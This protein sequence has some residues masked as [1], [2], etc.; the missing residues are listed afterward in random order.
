MCCD[1]HPFGGESGASSDL[2]G[3]SVDFDVDQTH[4]A[5]TL[6]SDALVV[7]KRWYI[8]PRLSYGIKYTGIGFAVDR[9]PVYLNIQLPDDFGCVVTCCCDQLKFI[10]LVLDPI[11]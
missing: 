8:E 4:P 3:S 5:S 1:R 6:W 10:E 7:T 11:E 9:D 2:F